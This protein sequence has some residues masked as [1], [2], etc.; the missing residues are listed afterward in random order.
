[1]ALDIGSLIAKVVADTSDF[2]A[3]LSS[4]GESVEELDQKLDTSSRNLHAWAAAGASAA[5]A[6]TSAL[7]IATGRSLGPIM[8]Q[9][10]ALDDNIDRLRAYRAAMMEAG[11]SGSGFRRVLF[12]LDESLGQAATRGGGTAQAFERLGLSVEQLRDPSMEAVDQLMLVIG[13]LHRLEHADEQAALSRQLLG[14]ASR[15]FLPAIRQGTEGIEASRRAHEHILVPL[16]QHREAL[17][18][19]VNATSRVWLRTRE[20]AV[21]LT[22]ALMPAMQ[23]LADI[24]ELVLGALAGM[25]RELREILGGW[26]RWI[27]LTVGIGAA[28]VVVIGAVSQFVRALRL[29]AAAKASVLALSGPKGWAMLAVGAGVA[30]AAV[31]AINSHFGDLEEGID[32]TRTA[33]QGLMGDFDRLAERGQSA[34][35]DLGLYWRLREEAAQRAWDAQAQV[36]DALDRERQTLGMTQREIQLYTLATNGA[37]DATM[38]WAREYIEAIEAFERNEAIEDQLRLLED[39]VVALLMSREELELHRL[40]QLGATD[41]QLDYARGLQESIQLLREQADEQRRLERLAQTAIQSQTSAVDRLLA[42]QQDLNA[43]V[44]TGLLDRETALGY[45]AEQA[46]QMGLIV[47]EA[48]ALNAELRQMTG[49]FGEFASFGEIV[50][51]GSFTVPEPRG[52]E[53]AEPHY[54]LNLPDQTSQRDQAVLVERVVELLEE[55]RRNTEDT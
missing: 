33:A 35:A 18:E 24:L 14:T 39:Q 45:L 51:G 52:A 44:E 2:E 10:D 15:E 46:K 42:L 3:N 7:V 28:I 12:R 4:A 31:M 37:S 27:G 30:A 16:E 6:A 43:A 36:V 53:A 19:M 34:V 22:L 21:E 1:M 38:A 49:Q 48:E 40:A 23:D 41:A 47:D 54:S 13:A 9:A 55:I 5:L 32:D 25:A 26:T 11:V 8:D 20:F 29:L 50:V 17:S